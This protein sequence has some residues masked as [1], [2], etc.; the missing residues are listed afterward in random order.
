MATAQ[1]AFLLCTRHLGVGTVQRTYGHPQEREATL[2]FLYTLRCRGGN[3][4]VGTT[5]NPDQRLAQHLGGVGSAWTKAHPPTHGAF[6]S[7]KPVAPGTAAGLQEDM[8]VKE[9][10]R[11]HGVD[12]VRGGSYCQLVLPA[13]QR[14]TLATELRHADSRCTK[15][16]ADDHWASQ[17]RQQS[18]GEARRGCTRCGRDSHSVAQCYATTHARGG[19]VAARPDDDDDNEAWS[20]DF[21][22]W[23]DDD[24]LDAGASRPLPTVYY[25]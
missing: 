8:A 10:M 2:M 14:S 5:S 4:Y 7:V 23:S 16:G 21:E 19:R 9:L 22:A 25:A 17:C 13:A 11:R 24:D 18:G 12:K 20:E 3:W 1:G 6:A 15:C